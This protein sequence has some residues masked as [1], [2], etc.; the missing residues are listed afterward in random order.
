MARLEASYE[1]AAR[2][3]RT[4]AA[5]IAPGARRTQVATPGRG[6]RVTVPCRA[7]WLKQPFWERAAGMGGP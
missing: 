6:H 5:G 7:N 2:V 3:G 4:G 1:V